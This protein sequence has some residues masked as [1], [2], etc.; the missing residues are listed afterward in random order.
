VFDSARLLGF[1]AA[2]FVL[3]IVP[4]PNTVIILA[5]SISGGRRAGLAT[6]AG[7][8]LGTMF[9]TLA[10]AL[11]ISAILASSDLAFTIVKFAGVVYL[12]I[13]G[14]RSIVRATSLGVTTTQPL[15]ARTAFRRALVTN[16]LNPKSAIFFLAFLPQ[17]VHPERNHLFLQFV[18]LGLIVVAVGAAIGSTLALASGALTDWLQRHS[19]FARWQPR[20]TGAI[21]IAV[22]L[23]L[24]LALR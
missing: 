7:V 16:L 22:A 3:V 11:G 9:H 17:F 1:V 24:A 5:Q 23:W 8:E 12:V 10:A 14:L 4:G 19:S 21:L 2:V 20:V 13:V 15:D 18:I 6:V